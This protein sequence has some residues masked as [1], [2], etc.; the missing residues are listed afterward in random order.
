VSWL[1]QFSKKVRAGY[2]FAVAAVAEGIG[3]TEFYN[4]MFVE[5]LAGKRQQMFALH[6]GIREATRDKS[7]L[8][9]F[10]PDAIP[11]EALIPLA[12]T[13]QLKRY[14]YKIAIPYE[15]PFSQQVEL[16][17]STVATSFLI[18]QSDAL[19]IAEKDLNQY[20]RGIE[21]SARG[22]IKDIFKSYNPR[23]SI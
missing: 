8:R 17:H 14:H 10:E 12:V 5:G 11:D 7:Y 2:S 19:S 22:E 1:D 23:V 4:M 6:K 21:P 18:P 9:P 15:D 16:F 13:S 20:M 3:P